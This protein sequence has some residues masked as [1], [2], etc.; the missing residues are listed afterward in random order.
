MRI[1]KIWNW[2][3]K[4]CTVIILA[5]KSMKRIYQNEKKKKQRFFII[6]FR[7]I[8]LPLI[9]KKPEFWTTW[10]YFICRSKY[11]QTKTSKVLKKI[12]NRWWSVSW[13]SLDHFFRPSWSLKS[14]QI[15]QKIILVTLRLMFSNIFCRYVFSFCQNNIWYDNLF[16]F[17]WIRLNEPV[18]NELQN[19]QQQGTTG[20]GISYNFLI[21]FKNIIWQQSKYWLE[22]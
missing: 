15:V 2:W 19:A 16:V 8:A 22:G 3:T 12:I 13:W 20:T 18:G 11:S 17:S 1:V 7:W 21:L 4:N 10:K 14:V 9:Y 5:K 6:S